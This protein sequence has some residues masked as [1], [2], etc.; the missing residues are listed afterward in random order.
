MK[1]RI[2]PRGT[3]WPGYLTGGHRSRAERNK[4][5]RHISFGERRSGG[6]GKKKEKN[7]IRLIGETAKKWAAVRVR[8]P[9]LGGGRLEQ[10]CRKKPKQGVPTERCLSTQMWGTFYN[11]YF[12]ALVRS[13]L[14]RE[15]G[16]RSFQ[17]R[18]T[19]AVTRKRWQTTLCIHDLQ[20]IG[21]SISLAPD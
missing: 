21:F 16:F 9:D 5:G 15:N 20:G 2:R 1:Q 3:P 8:P 11:L 19:T 7:H 13:V 14:E 17:G 12:R 10:K 18:N 4:I 6:G